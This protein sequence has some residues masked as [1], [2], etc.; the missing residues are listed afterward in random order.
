MQTFKLIAKNDNYTEIVLSML[1]ALDFIEVQ[2]VNNDK[3]SFGELTTNELYKISYQSLKE[4]WSGEE[5]EIWE[6][7]LTENE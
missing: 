2:E 7:Y 6:S 1:K 5:N 4:D 3:I